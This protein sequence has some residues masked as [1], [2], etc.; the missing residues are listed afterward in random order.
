MYWSWILE[1]IGLVGAFY[2]GRKRWWAWTL[3]LGN[4]V[5]WTIYGITTEQYGFVTASG[6]Y[7]IVYFRN[8]RKW[9]ISSR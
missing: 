7:G 9:Y 5:L 6:F 3:L 2:A 8:A 4:A 1:G